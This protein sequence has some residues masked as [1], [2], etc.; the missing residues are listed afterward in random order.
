MRLVC[1]ASALRFRFQSWRSSRIHHGSI[2]A[3]DCILSRWNSGHV[4]ATTPPVFD[5]KVGFTDY[6]KERRE[7]HIRVPEYFNFANVLD[8][9][10][11]KEKTGERTENNPAFW[12]VDDKGKEIK[13][14]FQKL[15]ENSRRTANIL[16][17]ACDVQRGDRVMVILPRL[18]EWWLIN[19]ACL[20][21][22]TIISPG[23]TQLRA[24]DIESRLL[25]S[26]ATC[27]IAD[28][29]SAAFVDEVANCSPYL[30]SKLLVKEDEK[31]PDRRGWL[32]FQDLYAQA[33]NEHQCEETLSNE[34]VTVFFTSGTTGLPKMAEH[35]H[36]SCGLGHI[37]TGKFWLDNI[38]EDVHW[39]LSDTGWA[40]SAYSSFFGP[41]SQGACV[42]VYHKARFE[43]V[44]ILDALQKYPIS[45]FCSAPTAYRMMIQE[46]LSKYKFP[47]LRHC[48]SAGE[49][50]N[51]EVGTEWRE[52]T[53]LEI[54]EGYG[55]TETTLLCGTFRCLE[56]RPGSMGKPAPGC[57][58]KIVDEQGNECPDGVEGEVV[59]EVSSNRP[60]G[61]FNR[62]VDD[63]DRTNAVLHDNFYWTGDKAYKDKDGY[64]YFV[65]RSDDVI[66]SA[67]YRIGPF[68]VE[69]ALIEHQAVA[70]AAVVSSPDSLRGEIVKAFVTLSP[71]FT[72]DREALVQELQDHVKETTAPYK[73]P[74]KI[75]FVDSL[76]KTVSGKIRRVELRQKEWS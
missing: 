49:P 27:I 18:P 46:D 66:L 65:G 52:M 23:S 48:I 37:T 53:G 17:G 28:Q 15:T 50:L 62:Y 63:P 13:W 2:A 31:T 19:I 73:Y 67:G 47:S 25:A 64:F 5:S 51:P 39:N 54:R 3:I 35:T 7:F 74:R 24:K 8:E 21:T 69:S 71:H 41:W 44:S 4:H 14:S 76:P 30:K 57:N 1:L 22:G 16:A 10:A 20:R 29:E 72:G 38:P 26:K 40:K 61:L 11:Q 58:L 12:W 45:T 55:Q 68:E 42:F 59:V 56:N 70:E 34:P 36:A 60:V 43:P 75:E 9:W 33:S 32:P 6:E